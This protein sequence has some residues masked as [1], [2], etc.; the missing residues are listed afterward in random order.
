MMMRGE[1]LMNAP[2]DKFWSVLE[3]E[4]VEVENLER[5]CLSLQTQID[6]TKRVETIRHAPGFIDLLNAIKGLHALA[7]EKL[8]GDERLTNEGMR[9]QRGRVRGLESVL[10]LLINP[11]VNATLAE[12]LVERKNQLAEALRRRPKPKPKNEEPKVET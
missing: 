4:R 5:E 2:D 7:R 3:R 10:S 1:D 9:E 6:V 8:V 12:R 11:Q